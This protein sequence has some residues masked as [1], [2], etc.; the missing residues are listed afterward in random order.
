MG[1]L[2]QFERRLD[3]I[4]FEMRNVKNETKILFEMRNVKNMIK[5]LPSLD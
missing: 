2:S 1:Q 5:I 4:L 3:N